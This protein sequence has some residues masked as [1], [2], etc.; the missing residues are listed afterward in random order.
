MDGK[1]LSQELAD[2]LRA[3]GPVPIFVARSAT[4]P[5]FRVVRVVLDCEFKGGR[6]FLIV[7]PDAGVS[8]AA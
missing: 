5:R 6:V 4:A 1:R 7:E 2:V 8:K 3:A